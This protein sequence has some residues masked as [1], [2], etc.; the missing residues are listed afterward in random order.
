M[1]WTK[2]TKVYCWANYYSED[3]KWV[4]WDEDK[5]VQGTRKFFNPQTRKYEPKS[6]FKV[7]WNL[8]NLETG[9]IVD[10]EFKTLRSAKEYAETH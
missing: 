3:G 8:K 9:E 6:V 2:E 7:W 5:L 10:R 1:K 4:A